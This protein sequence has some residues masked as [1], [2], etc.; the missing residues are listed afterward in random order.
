EDVYFRSNTRFV[1]DFMGKANFLS[2]TVTGTAPEGHTLVATTV[3]P[4]LCE[5]ATHVSPG[6]SGMVAVRMEFIQV[7]EG[8]RPEPLPANHAVG[9]VTSVV[10]LGETREV[11]VQAGAEKLMLRVPSSLALVAGQEV[12]LYFN[13]LG[14]RF[15]TE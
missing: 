13:P 3:G 9:T 1:V 5:P 10:F 4:L 8:A 14:C 7:M 15:I 12:L 11:E 6:D 2:G